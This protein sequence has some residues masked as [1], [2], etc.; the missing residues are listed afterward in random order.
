M[1][2]FDQKQLRRDYTI[3]PTEGIKTGDTKHSHEAY[4]E[5]HASPSG[6]TAIKHKDRVFRTETGSN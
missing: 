2:P 5:A 1:S 4:T 6:R 3:R